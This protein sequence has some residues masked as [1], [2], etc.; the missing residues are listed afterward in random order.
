MAIAFGIGF[1]VLFLSLI[2]YFVY[3]NTGD[4]AGEESIEMPEWFGMIGPSLAIG[5]LGFIIGAIV[6]GLIKK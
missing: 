5:V 2:A 6:I 1:G 3:R 4:G